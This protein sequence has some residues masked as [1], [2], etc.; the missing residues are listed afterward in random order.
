MRIAL[1]GFALLAVASA[2]AARPPSSALYD[3]TLTI[4]LE[5]SWRIT[6][7]AGPGFCAVR[8]EW[9]GRR[10]V[11]LRTLRTRVR[12]PG[13]PGVAFSL[14]GLTG[15]ALQGGTHESSRPATGGSCAE[16]HADCF[17]RRVP[18]ASGTA[19]ATFV[20]SGRVRLDRLRYAERG[21]QTW[22]CLPEGAGSRDAP[23]D[24]DD[25]R[26]RQG[27]FRSLAPRI[28]VHSAVGRSSHADGP[29]TSSSL[30]ER[31]EWTLVLRRR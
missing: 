6:T 23:L 1:V 10:V 18:L 21:D 26:V 17:P 19:R 27:G 5:S 12:L 4:R 7:I 14:R 28:V 8:D 25:G 15:S 3:A 24:L 22:W 30:D 11:T 13:R 20:G 16:A 31:V 29:Q 9:S 2:A